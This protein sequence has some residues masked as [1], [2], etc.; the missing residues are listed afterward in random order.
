MSNVQSLAVKRDIKQLL[1]NRQQM[2]DILNSLQHPEVLFSA[3]PLIEEVMT[4]EGKLNTDFWNAMI[5]PDFTIEADTNHTFH[6]KM[7]SLLP[8]YVN[9]VPTAELIPFLEVHMDYMNGTYPML[10]KSPGLDQDWVQKTIQTYL[11][12]PG[13]PGVWGPFG[14]ICK[15]IRW[16]F[17][18]TDFSVIADENEFWKFQIKGTIPNTPG[19]TTVTVNLKTAFVDAQAIDEMNSRKEDD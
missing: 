18:Y 1:S 19:C 3:W 10:A 13:T 5:C 6:V 17:D 14:V 4:D 7:V 16:M 15:A 11:D 2:M 9:G 12:S 8:T